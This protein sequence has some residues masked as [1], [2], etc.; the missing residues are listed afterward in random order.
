MTQATILNSH[1]TPYGDPMESF[2]SPSIAQTVKV[3]L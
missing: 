3:S 1:T 2:F